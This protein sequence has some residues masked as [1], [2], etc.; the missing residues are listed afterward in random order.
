MSGCVVLRC[1]KSSSR[2]RQVRV[3]NQPLAI[4]DNTPHLFESAT[5]V[6]LHYDEYTDPAD[7]EP[8][9]GEVDRE[10]APREAVV[11]IVDEAGLTAR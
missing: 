10:D 3:V 5:G 9:T 7:G 11:E 4:D 6:F 1:S 8:G 2:L